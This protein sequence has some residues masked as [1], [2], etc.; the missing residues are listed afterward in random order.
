M[1]YLEYAS[2]DWISEYV[3]II[4]LPQFGDV[5]SNFEGLV[6]YATGFGV[7]A[8]EPGSGT[9]ILLQF[10]NMTVIR[11][12]DCASFYGSVI[13]ENKICTDTSTG[14]STW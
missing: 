2:Q 12:E 8:D 10:T 9:S 13:N 7:T 14:R 3:D 6:G 1:I 4:L 5:G 11:N